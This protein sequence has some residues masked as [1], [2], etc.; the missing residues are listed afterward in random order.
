M[1]P[2]WVK[3]VTCSH[4]SI[5]G[6][7]A[8]ILQFTSVNKYFHI[9]IDNSYFRTVFAAFQLSDEQSDGLYMIGYSGLASNQTHHA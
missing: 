9:Y 5:N 2:A 4:H 6:D 3:Y 7:H 1:C 8:S